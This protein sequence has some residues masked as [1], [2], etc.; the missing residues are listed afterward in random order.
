MSHPIFS[1]KVCKL[2]HTVI[3]QMLDARALAGESA[4]VTRNEVADRLNEIL[5]LE[6]D[7]P[8]AWTAEAVRV[9]LRS[10]AFDTE[11]RMFHDMPGRYGGIRDVNVEEY[12]AAIERQKRLAER[13]EKR[14]LEKAAKEAE[15]ALAFAKEVVLQ[16]EAPAEVTQTEHQVH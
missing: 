12:K 6:S 4:R 13:A 16:T 11:Q 1:Q 14:K 5:C 2:G 10:E 9:A 3:A 8:Q 15:E 7:S